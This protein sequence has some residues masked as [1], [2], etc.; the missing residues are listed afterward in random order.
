MG[1]WWI[2]LQ[3]FM[4]KVN[5]WI[6]LCLLCKFKNNNILFKIVNIMKLKFMDRFSFRMCKLLLD[7]LKN[8]IKMHVF[9]GRS[10][11]LLFRVDVGIGAKII[12]RSF[13]I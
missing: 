4:Y 12:F 2:I 10:K 1:F 13:T 11:F 6:E 9:A 7:I 8:K 5:K 3:I